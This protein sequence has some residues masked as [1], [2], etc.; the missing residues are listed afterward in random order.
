MTLNSSFNDLDIIY[1]NDNPQKISNL[2]TFLDNKIPQPIMKKND[3]I[4]L[5]VGR[6]NIILND[7]AIKL[8]AFIFYT[9]VFVYYYVDGKFY[10]DINHLLSCLTTD[11]TVYQNTFRDFTD[12]IANTIWTG[13]EARPI[14]RYLIDFNTVNEII[15]LFSNNE[16]A[17]LFMF[18]CYCQFYAMG[19]ILNDLMK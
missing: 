4:V 17:K 5:S 11:M 19:V 7:R 2:E 18:Q 3:A 1:I 10:V 13:T 14:Y 12:S 8:S 6:S 9:N 16:F 15:L